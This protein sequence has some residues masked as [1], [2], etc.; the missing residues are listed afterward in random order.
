MFVESNRISGHQISI[1]ADDVTAILKESDNRT[2]SIMLKTSG[3]WLL[4]KDEF[5][6]FKRR[7]SQAFTELP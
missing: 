1:R 5:E 2:V 4:L 3:E 7:L 6:S